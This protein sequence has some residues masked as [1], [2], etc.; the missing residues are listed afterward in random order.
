MHALTSI[1]SGMFVAS[2]TKIC[3]ELLHLSQRDF[4][5]ASVCAEL[6][7]RQGCIISE[8]EIYQGSEKDKE[9]RGDLMTQGL[10]DQQ[11][12]SII[13]IKLGDAYAD[14]YKYEPMPVLLNQ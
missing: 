12:K 5:P 6:L 8:K 14:S 13:D 3:D 1:T 10:W 11:F 9:T 7:I 2:H 4:I